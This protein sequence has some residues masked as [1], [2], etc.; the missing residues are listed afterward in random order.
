M[1]Y[2]EVYV[3]NPLAINHQG[4]RVYHVYRRDDANSTLR[5]YHYALRR[6]A[7]EANGDDFDIRDLPNYDGVRSH[8]E[9]LREAVEKRFITG[10]EEEIHLPDPHE[11]FTEHPQFPMDQWREEVAAGDTRLGYDEW[12][13][14]QIEQWE[15][16]DDDDE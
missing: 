4:V 2:I 13:L 15:N 11:R 7:T 10:D 3:D 1:P 16:S 5:E 12:V 9:I 8:E 14:H 6:D